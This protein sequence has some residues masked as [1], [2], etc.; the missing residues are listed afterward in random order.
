[1]SEPQTNGNKK[2][3]KNNSK[4][5]Y[6]LI[7]LFL[8]GTNSYLYFE[9]KKTETRLTISENQ[10]EDTRTAKEELDSIL[11][12]T[13]LQLEDYRGEN[14]SL[15][16]II[17]SRNKELQA[18]ANEINE[19]LRSRKISKK[20]LDRALEQLDKFKYYAQKY[21]KEIE[22]LNQEITELRTEN[23]KIKEHN[24]ELSQRSERFE[25]KTLEYQNKFNLAKKLSA[26]NVK[27]E[28]IRIRGNGAESVTPKA[29]KA[30]QLKITFIF[31]DNPIA[32]KGEKEVFVRIIDPDGVTL[33]VE[34]TGS[35]K[36][37]Q[38]GQQTIYTVK[39]SITFDNSGD[40]VTIYWK[41]GA[42]YPKGH[43]N[44]EI[45]CE[46]FQIGKGSFDL[47]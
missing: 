43:Y 16:Q 46:G 29:N 40:P 20:E 28:G 15:N 34:E 8:L 42:D 27:G 24:R 2:E 19:L 6:F 9:Y 26:I 18:R 5:I 32:D 17:D 22:K 10:Y 30:E 11:R 44:I 38:D 3:K 35:G 4:I 21:Q 37:L 25:L 13:Q 23:D 7:I 33:S 31:T 39:K 12:A 41:K 36:F 45:Y 14:D 1:M 47:K